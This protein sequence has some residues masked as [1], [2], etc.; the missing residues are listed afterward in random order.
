[1]FWSDEELALLDGTAVA[2]KMAQ[3]PGARLAMQCAVEPPFQVRSR[4][5]VF[6]MPC[7]TIQEMVP[8]TK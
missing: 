8:E 2:A 6:L 5:I 1:M 4:S 3:G 7:I